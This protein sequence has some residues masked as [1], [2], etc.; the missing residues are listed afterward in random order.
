MLSNRFCFAEFETPPITKKPICSFFYSKYAGKISSTFRNH[1]VI[2]R[3][4]LIIEIFAT[5]PEY[6]VDDDQDAL[7]KSGQTTAHYNQSKIKKWHSMPPIWLVNLFLFITITFVICTRIE[8]MNMLSNLHHIFRLNVLVK[9]QVLI[10]Q[11]SLKRIVSN[12]PSVTRHGLRFGYRIK[13]SQI[14]KWLSWSR[15]FC[16]YYLG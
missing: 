4:L 9:L 5:Y 10:V 2:D 11:G 8:L 15:S 1:P 7:E 14:L 16:G 13:Q 12:T 3:P 6:G